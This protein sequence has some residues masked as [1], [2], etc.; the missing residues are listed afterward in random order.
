[1]CK[2]WRL[3][4]QGLF[5]GGG[6]LAGDGRCRILLVFA[7]ECKWLQVIMH[8]WTAEEVLYLLYLAYGQLTIDAFCM[9]EFGLTSFPFCLIC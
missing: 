4:E 5:D 9:L 1:M 8:V 2:V 3:S 6:T 7:Y